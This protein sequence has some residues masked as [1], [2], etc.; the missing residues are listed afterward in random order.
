MWDPYAEFESVTLPNGLRVYKAH[1]PDRSWEYAGF[2]IHSGSLSD[3][4]GKEGLA[5]FVEHVLAEN[6][7]V[8]HSEM[9]DFFERLGGS[10]RFGSTGVVSTDL[11]FFIPAEENALTQSLSWFG[12]ML[13][14]AELRRKIDTEREVILREAYNFATPSFRVSSHLSKEFYAG[15]IHHVLGTRESVSRITKNDLQGFY[16]THYIPANM[17]V[18]GVGGVPFD[19]FVAAISQS[20]LGERKGG[21]QISLPSSKCALADVLVNYKEMQVKSNDKD[22]AVYWSFAK[23]P[24]NFDYWH[25]YINVVNSV[26]YDALFKELRNR[27]LVYDVGVEDRYCRFLV[28]VSFE[29]CF[30]LGKE[31]EVSDV[32]DTVLQNIGTREDLFERKKSDFQAD[33][34]MRDVSGKIALSGVLSDLSSYRRVIPA[35]EEMALYR[36]VTMDDVHDV[37]QR[38]HPDKRITFII[39]PE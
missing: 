35:D 5:H 21:E 31:K 26:F 27:G 25:P 8:S 7:A 38:F 22:S 6:A 34:L 15:C 17:S 4:V 2:L 29:F 24:Q 16:D 23:I 18:V 3:P 36:R 20:P 1:W 19:D 9:E 14:F 37:L 12:S 30:P 28:E 32:V 11:S 13:L 33:I 39:S 10:A